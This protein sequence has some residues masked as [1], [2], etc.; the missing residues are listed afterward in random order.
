MIAHTDV[1]VGGACQVT[2]NSYQEV[3]ALF[4][5]GTPIVPKPTATIT[6]PAANAVVTSSFRVN[7]LA[8]SKRGVFSL[9]LLLNGYPWTSTLGAAF[10]CAEVSAVPAGT[11]AGVGQVMVGV[12]LLT[13]S[14][15]VAEAVL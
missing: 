6:S 12:A 13:V 11:D 8:G 4:G 14:V 1:A 9:N 3:L 15:T 10:S 2:Q 5:S 7:A